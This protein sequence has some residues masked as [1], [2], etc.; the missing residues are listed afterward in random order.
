MKSFLL[1][2]TLLFSAAAFAQLPTNGLVLSLPFT[3]NANDA[4]GN[5]NN[6]TVNGATLTTDR[7]GNPDAAYSFNGSSDYI[8]ISGATGVNNIEYSYSLWVKPTT[9]PANGST[10]NIYEIGTNPN[11]D[12]GQ[13]MGVDNNYV[14]YTGWTVG[15][16][17]TNHSHTL[18]QNGVLPSTDIWYNLIITRSTTTTS[19]YVN[20]SLAASTATESNPYYLNPLDIYI[21]TRTQLFQF[22]NGV[23]DDISIYNRV[24]TS[25]EITG[26]VTSSV[27]D[28]AIVE[29]GLY[30]N[31]SN[32]KLTITLNTPMLDG[33][34][35]VYN[36]NGQIVW[37][38]KNI[39][40]SSVI[41]DI[42]SQPDGSYIIEMTQ[43]GKTIRSKFIKQ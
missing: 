20:G 21:G 13:V 11:T 42:S 26:I 12:Y 10:T 5:G 27:E 32:G 19:L 43:E 18:F 31:P 15:N 29:M 28:D 35:K 23:I 1:S 7:F 40:G 22:W 9:L 17:N 34:V 24:L 6:G 33:S 37:E 4:S 41:A 25:S 39:A 8:K 2:I 36:S 16:G 3:G 14:G 30:P 38:K